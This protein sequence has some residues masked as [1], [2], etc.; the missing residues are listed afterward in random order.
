MLNLGDSYRRLGRTNDA[1][2]A[3]RR[4][5]ELADAILLQNPKDGAIRA[6]VAYFALR[7]GD[8]ARAEQELTQALNS[9]GDNRTVVRRAAI[10]Y[11]ALG[12]RD[13]ALAVLESAPPDVLRELSRQPDVVALRSDPRFLALLPRSGTR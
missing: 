3:Y 1:D 10:C 7:L 8:R 2:S 12:Q 4:A 5:R 11:E 13:R 9:S 6:F